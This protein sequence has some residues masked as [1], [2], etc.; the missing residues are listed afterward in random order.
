MTAT[1]TVYQAFDQYT[2]TVYA[3]LDATGTPRAAANTVDLHHLYEDKVSPQAAASYFRD[4]YLDL[5][6][7]DKFLP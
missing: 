7:A 2:A 3:A 5:A 4:S 6:L 1:S